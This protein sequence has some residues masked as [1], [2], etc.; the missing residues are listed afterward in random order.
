MSGDHHGDPVLPGQ[1]A[2]GVQQ[3]QFVSVIQMRRRLVH[4]DQRRVLAERPC[5][6]DQPKF[7]TG[8]GV[9]W[10]VGQCFDPGLLQCLLA[11][12]VVILRGRAEGGQI[13]RASHEDR[14]PY[15]IWKCDGMILWHIGDMTG[16]GFPVHSGQI[17]SVQQNRS[18]VRHMKAENRVEQGALTASVGTHDTQH[19]S[20]RDIKGHIPKRRNYAI[21]ETQMIYLKHH[22]QLPP[23]V[24]F[25]R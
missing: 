19:R 14:F 25:S 22:D 18:G 7:P 10:A 17:L 23:L 9:I 12:D 5:E 3:H 15:G 2:D 24:F 16:D 4:Q 1:R 11:A 6:K 20:R 13:R 8:N 21:G